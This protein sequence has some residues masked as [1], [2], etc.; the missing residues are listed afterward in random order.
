[1]AHDD[2]MPR[3]TLGEHL[4]EFRWRLIYALVGLAV[5]MGVC[6]AFGQW[7]LAQLRWPYTKVMADLG[8]D[9]PLQVLGATQGFIIYLKVS[10]IG[11]LILSAPWGFYQMW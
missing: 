11:G 2:D 7:I 8:R 9:A 4:D 1:M 3:M 10:L 6:L 5:A